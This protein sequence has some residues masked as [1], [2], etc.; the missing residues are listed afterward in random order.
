[1]TAM[2]IAT[3]LLVALLS[4]GAPSSAA[5]QTQSGV[6]MEAAAASARALAARKDMDAARAIV[7]AANAYASGASGGR[8][9]PETQRLAF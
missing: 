6:S 4:A 9:I 2:R 8:T 7:R 1:M 3:L 5:A